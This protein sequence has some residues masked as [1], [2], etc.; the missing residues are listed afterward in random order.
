MV[1]NRQLCRS[2]RSSPEDEELEH[3][4]TMHSPSSTCASPSCSG[5]YT[6][7]T[8]VDAAS[9]MRRPADYVPEN[10]TTG[11]KPRRSVKPAS[12]STI[13]H[14]SISTPSSSTGML[15][16]AIRSDASDSEDKTSELS[17]PTKPHG[18]SH[19]TVSRDAG[20][21]EVG[22]VLPPTGRTRRHSL[23]M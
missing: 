12:S 22:E 21:R 23:A 20:E 4:S 7:L 8:F 15:E 3:P 16:D 9:K 13:R 5:R 11:G 6:I 14:S 19:S 10:K 1:Q 17:F 18:R 2:W